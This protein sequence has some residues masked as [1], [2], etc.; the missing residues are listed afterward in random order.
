MN[1]KKFK[2][3]VLPSVSNMRQVVARFPYPIEL[4]KG[5][6][7]EMEFIMKEGQAA[8]LLSGV[9]IRQFSFVW[10]CSSWGSR[11]LAYAI[12]LYLEKYKI[13]YTH[14]EKGTSKVTDHMLFSLN[15]IPAPDTLYVGRKD[16]EKNLD[17]I[18]EVCGYPLI[19]KDIKGCQG[20]HLVKVESEKELLEKLTELPRHKKYIF[21]RYICN[22][23]DWGV[24]VADGVVVSGQKRF[25][26]DGEFRNNVHKGAEEIFV[27]PVDIPEDLKQ[28]AINTGR[29][30]GLAWSRTDIIIDEKT[31]KP[32]VL[33]VNRL[34]GITS[35]TSDVEG[36]YIFLST[37]ITA[38][39]KK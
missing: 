6:Y 11:D 13:P 15:G 10:L 22:C 39:A 18:R 32:Y 2:L 35:K 38:I 9:D 31:Q 8:I 1:E 4:T 14:V 36:A 29:A 28:M 17:R 16:V 21:Q 27:D 20:A 19:I 5:K 33:E 26:C 12:Q 7:K 30:L 23:F 34:P 37:Q 3:L 24:M 25:A